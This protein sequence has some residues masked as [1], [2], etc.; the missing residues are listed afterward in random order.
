MDLNYVGAGLAL[1]TFKTADGNTF[2]A[3]G[4]VTAEGSP[5][6][7]VIEIR[8][9]D[10]KLAEFVTEQNES[11]SL[12]FNA[13]T[14]DVLQAITGNNYASSA[15][16]IEIPV[17]TDS[18]Q[19]PPY[20]EITAK[21]LARSEGGDTGYFYKTW[22]KCQIKNPQISQSQGSELAVE[23]EGLA[24]KTSTDVE[25]NSLSTARTALWRFQANA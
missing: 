16:G 4:S 17:G 10:Q 13:L 14:F 19:N 24:Y 21:S 15:E 2:T 20:V 7:E 25:G 1:V 22:Y 9:D 8:G 23:M 18:E 11:I 12:Q 6:S 3:Y 5:E